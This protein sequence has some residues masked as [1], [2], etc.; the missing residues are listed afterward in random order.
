MSATIKRDLISKFQVPLIAG[1]VIQTVINRTKE[2]NGTKKNQIAALIEWLCSKPEK[3]MSRTTWIPIQQD[4][5]IMQEV[6]NVFF[7]TAEMISLL[8][9]FG[10]FIVAD[11]TYKTT[12]FGRLLIFTIR[13]G[14]GAFAIAALL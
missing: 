7:V 9:H 4:G 13:V 11:A 14:I 3:F 5:V 10:K 2:S 6:G 12:V 1:H 8:R